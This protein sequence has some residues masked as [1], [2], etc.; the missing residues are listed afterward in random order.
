[1]DTKTKIAITVSIIF[2][3]LG[4][5]ATE[6]EIIYRK[7]I[8]PIGVCTQRASI[9]DL[10]TVQNNLAIYNFLQVYN[11]SFSVYASEFISTCGIHKVD[12]VLAVAIGAYEGSY[13]RNGLGGN[14]YGITGCGGYCYYAT[15]EEGIAE[16]CKLLGKPFYRNKTIPEINRNYAPVNPEWSWAIST[17]YKKI[18]SYEP[19]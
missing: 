9:V 7:G 2:I 5:F 15:S 19:K 17:I 12:P 4:W 10:A 16:I 14:F 11:P 18:K 6:D 3:F 1:M 8:E 13:F